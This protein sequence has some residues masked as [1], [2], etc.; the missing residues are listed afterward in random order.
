MN[1][2]VGSYIYRYIIF[3]TIRPSGWEIAYDG[4]IIWGL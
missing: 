4:E 1:Y 3:D 2:S